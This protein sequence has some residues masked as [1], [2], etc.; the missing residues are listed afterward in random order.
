MRYLTDLAP[1]GMEIHWY[2]SMLLNGSVKWQNE[3]N[4][5]NAPFLQNGQQRISD[6][7]FMNYWW[8]ADMA[9]AS[10]DYV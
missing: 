10:R 2:D 8:N 7:M 6:A 4:Q 1:A 5:K 9:A 3:L